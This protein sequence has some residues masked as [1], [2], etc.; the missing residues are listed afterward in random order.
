MNR[1]F[2]VFASI[3]MITAV[4]SLMLV[5]G[6]SDNI[7]VNAN[8]LELNQ[9]PEALGGA[10]L[11]LFQ[12]PCSEGTITTITSELISKDDGGEIVID[13]EEYEHIFSVEPKAVDENVEISVKSYQDYVW[14]DKVIVFEFGPD[15][16][17]FDIPAKLTFEMRELSYRANY[18]K[19]LYYNPNQKSWV[20]VSV[21][22]VVDGEVVFNIDHFSKYAISD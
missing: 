19:L 11:H 1:K 21:K 15:G 14:G 3:G 13:R 7:P 16:L 20:L 17:V 18:G 5:A 8:S 9:S 22:Q 10:R 2:K 4:F 12:D 6:C